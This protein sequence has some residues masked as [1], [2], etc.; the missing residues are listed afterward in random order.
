MT[1][2]ELL[3]EAVLRQAS[4]LHITV[5]AP[6]VLRIHGSLVL[7]D[8]SPLTADATEKLF[9][10]IATAEQQAKFREQGEVDFSY[11]IPGFSRFRVNAFR[12]RGF[13]AIAVRVV[14]EKVPTLDELGHP[15]V[16]KTLARKPRGLVLV[17]GPTGSGK[18]TTLAAMIDLINSE[19]SCHIITL[20]DPIEYLHQHKKCIVN[21]REI[22]TD[23]RS[24]ANALRAALREDPDVILVGE[25]RDAETIG[26]AITAAETGHLVFATLHTGDA[27]QTID[28]IIDV[29]PPYQQ[30]QI[31]VQLSL[32]L[33]GIIAQQLLPRQD[34]R[35]RVAALEV[36]VATPA[37]RN[38]IREGK[39]H[40]LLSVIQTGG[41]VGMQTMDMALRDLYRRGLIS[42]E[43]ALAR[44]MDQEMFLKLIN[45]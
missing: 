40:Q 42:R 22:N 32:T 17:T 28:R 13:T 35:G 1:V 23:T 26:I 6:P 2:E 15:E 19:R 37:V 18:S 34:G 11:A 9:N 20:E 36:L 16:I 21:Q 41:K 5:G 45:G 8:S 33:Q 4:D 43:D 7:T 29:F 14:A 38:L 27:A 24:F 31:R 10:S 44:A 12:Q 3:R 30:Q 39:T 25:M